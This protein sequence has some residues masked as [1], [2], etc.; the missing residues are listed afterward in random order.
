MKLFAIANRATFPIQMIF[1]LN[2]FGIALWIPRIPDVKQALSL[3]L[4]S[5]SAAFF[6]M[7]A[8]TLIGFLLAPTVI[9]KLGQ[10]RAC[11]WAGALFLIVFI[12]PSLAWN[13]VSLALALFLSGL[14]VA[15][16]E[17]AMN[18]K[19]SQTQSEI[20][21]RIMSRCHGFW[22]IGA[23]LGAV[24]GGLFARAAIPFSTQQLLIEPVLALL[25]IWAGWNLR[26]DAPRQETAG[27]AFA[28]PTAAL[29]ALSVMPLGCMLAEG[30]MA[31]WSAIFAREIILASPW[32]T[33][34]T[35]TSFAVA[36][37]FG[38]LTGDW[39]T[40]TFGMDRTL[41]VSAILSAVGMLAFATS[42]T[43]VIAIPA[44]VMVGL[45]IA[46]VYPIAMTVAGQVPGQQAE[47]SVASV[48]FVAFMAFLVGPPVIGSIGHNFGL[49]FGL[50]LIAPVSLLPLVLMASGKLRVGA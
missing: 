10:R 16:I 27:P 35:F 39:V 23:A 14:A 1:L 29:L 37:A 30:A 25:T 9:R 44:A 18:A 22:S 36:M 38:R 31:E 24:T 2:S 47:K 32:M 34:M 46:N 6:A 13:L 26:P 11:I 3:S 42:T 49:P 48:A 20:G 15:T 41:V 8:G 17:V 19:A 28:L 12:L 45:G 5:I 33:A 21:I 4:L 7:P 50:A 40:H 43:L